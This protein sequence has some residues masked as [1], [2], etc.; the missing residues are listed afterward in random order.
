M[1]SNTSNASSASRALDRPSTAFGRVAV[2]RIH[3]A[4]APCATTFGPLCTQ[5]TTRPSLF[6]RRDLVNARTVAAAVGHEVNGN[7]KH[8][9]DNAGAPLR[10]VL[11]AVA[12]RMQVDRSTQHQLRKR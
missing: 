12:L 2:H 8:T 3:R 9:A 5:Q 7:G 11:V 6:K 10:Q 1:L 4:S